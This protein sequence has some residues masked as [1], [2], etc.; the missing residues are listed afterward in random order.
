MKLEWLRK[1]TNSE[2]GECPALYR[3]RGGYVVQGH[4]LDAETRAQL[5]QLAADEDAVFVPANVLD[6][7]KD[8]A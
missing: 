2:G 6:R 3:T 4:A 7:L 8:L 5:R 1:D